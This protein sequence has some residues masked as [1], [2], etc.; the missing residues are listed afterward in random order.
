MLRRYAALNCRKIVKSETAAVQKMIIYFPF[1]F[2]LLQKK[3][4]SIKNV[5]KCRRDEK[6]VVLLSRITYVLRQRFI[7]SVTHFSISIF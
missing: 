3:N 1:I 7:T 5:R 2:N 4:L 6:S